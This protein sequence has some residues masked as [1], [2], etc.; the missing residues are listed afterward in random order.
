MSEFTKGKWTA[1]DMGE[2]VFA[3]GF[4]MMIC[5]MRGWAYLKAQ[6]LSSDEIIDVQKAN[7]RL[8]AAAPEMYE[9]LFTLF[10]AE[11]I[12]PLD[13]EILR[14]KWE[15]LIPRIKGEVDEHD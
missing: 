15:E 2:Y 11:Y 1:D 9:M 14:R 10:N 4:N 8:I 6:C 7:A 3:H 5:Q 12:S 13:I